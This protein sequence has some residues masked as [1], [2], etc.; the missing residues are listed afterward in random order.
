M[1][2]HSV[3]LRNNYICE[4]AIIDDPFETFRNKA[5]LLFYTDR[6]CL[7]NARYG[8]EYADFYASGS[9]SV[10]LYGVDMTR[11]IR[12]HKAVALWL[13]C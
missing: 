3:S 11:F 9:D 7:L 1:A 2:I 4:R 5:G 10:R 8:Y 6:M 12:M 13:R